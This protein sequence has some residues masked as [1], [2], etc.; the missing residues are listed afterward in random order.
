MKTDYSFKELPFSARKHVR[1]YQF[2]QFLSQV[3]LG[4]GIVIFIL[5]LQQRG[6]NLYDISLIMAAFS[7]STLLFELP[8]GGLADGIG[9]KPV[10]IASLIA[11]IMSLTILLI[12]HSFI[13]AICAYAILGLSRALRSGTLDA[14]FVEKFRDVAPGFGT[15]PALAKIQ[16][17]SAVGLAMGAIFGGVL[18]DTLG[19]MLLP[20][21][22]GPY[23]A[24]LIFSIGLTALIIVYTLIF[25]Q[26]TSHAI[27]VTTIKSGF[28]NVPFIIKDSLFSATIHQIISILLVSTAL[29]S[30][31][32]F[33][34]ETFWVPF[35]KPM[36]VGGYAVSI[37]GIIS[38][39]HFGSMAVGA[40]VSA[41]FVTLF[42][43]SNIK[44]LIFWVVLTGLSLLALAFTQNV[45]YFVPIFILLNI[46]LGAQ[47]APEDS[48][49]HDYVPDDKRSTLL[50]LESVVI[51][52]G[53][54]IGMLSL[55]YIAELYDI[56]TAWILSGIIIT[57]IGLIYCLLP[58]RMANT[59]TVAHEKVDDE[60]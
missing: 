38:A 7:A 57:L 12:F 59:P 60:G 3:S 39:I 34:L 26:E 44:T 4:I 36:L 25:I 47:G 23:D 48:I 1:I 51:Q 5:L 22:F 2:Q 40:A 37:I 19:V 50:S 30:L 32:F 53:G 11:A 58:K 8:L 42:S 15:L 6:F 13:A 52:L 46:A 45:Y 27:N 54:L 49:F 10:Y 20:F 55:G 28:S 41:F 17:G 56:S 35:V 21:G 9:R 14:W 24:P 29:F 18:A 16:F 43:G 31:A 33:T